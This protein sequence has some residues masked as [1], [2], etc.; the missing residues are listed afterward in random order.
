MKFFNFRKKDTNDGNCCSCSSEN[1]S[2]NDES[3]D[4]LVLGGGCQKCNNLEN[5]LIEALKEMDLN[6]SV[7][8]VTDFEKIAAYGVMQ[9]PALVYKGKVLLTGTQ[10]DKNSLIN[11][12]KK[13]IF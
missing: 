4:L 6:L 8:H 11:L 12:L 5:N 7:G 3:C 1:K 9:T 2:S 10:T 13:E